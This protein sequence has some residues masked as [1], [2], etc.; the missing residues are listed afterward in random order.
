[1]P[2]SAKQLSILD[3]SSD[4]ERFFNENQT[5]LLSLL[6]RYIDISQFI[7]STFY[8]SY[9]S[10]FGRNR[11]YSIESMMSFFI[12]K[13]ILSISSIDTMISILSISSELR[14]YCNFHSIPH[15]SQ[16]SRFKTEFLDEI[17]DL[18]HNLV[19]HTQEISKEVNP[20]LSSILLTD[21]TGFE[22]YVKENNPKFYQR[23][24]SRAKAQYKALKKK[25]SDHSFNVEKYAQS[26]MPKSA[27]ANRDSKLCYLNGHFGYFQKTIVSTNGFGLIRDINFYD[28]DNNLSVDLMP[29]E[30]KDIYD[31]KSLIPALETFFCHH[32][33]FR[34]NYFIGDSGFDADDNYAYLHK[35]NIMPIIAINP[36]GSNPS[37]IEK[38]NENSVPLCPKDDSLEMV[39]DGITRGKNRSDR[40]KYIC[41]KVK[42]TSCKGKTS[43]VLK[44]EDPCSKSKCG[45]IKQLTVHHNYRYNASFPRNSIK[46]IRLF[47]LRTRIERTISQIK[48]FIQ[49][50]SLKIQ[51]TKSLKSEIIL[52]CISQLVSF[53][54]L[55]NVNDDFK[56]PLAIK[57]LAA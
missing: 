41:P 39:Y 53:I 25:D 16:F 30:L 33:D 42:K 15:K 50:K 28:S 32:P 18:F 48:N 44:C 7:P 57:A 47:K 10:R 37:C 17:H 21:T 24:V 45:K 31:A 51:N 36:R 20:F 11:K 9:Y 12:L 54:L 29:K 26:Q 14:S 35:K 56:N 4:F 34:Y 46:W 23:S 22:H 43:Y 5:N 40:I 19:D 6:D 2:V 38:F 1:M 55:Y 13:N 3:F 49:I 52:A 8:R 27:S